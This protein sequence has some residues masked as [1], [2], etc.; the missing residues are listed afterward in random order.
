[1]LS[2]QTPDNLTFSYKGPSPDEG[3]LP[4]LFYFSL[5]AEQSLEMYPYNSP[6]D[7]FKESKC[8]VFSVTLPSHGK[9]PMEHHAIKMW[10]D[11]IYAGHYQLE[12][13]INAVV[14]GIYFLIE[15][16]IVDPEA[17][18][19]SGL[20][21]GAFIAT[22]LAAKIKESKY[23]LGFAPLTY[24]NDLEDF[25]KYKHDMHVQSRLERLNLLSL[26]EELSHLH[27]L[28]FYIGNRD[29]RVGVDHCY[30]FI[31]AL[32]EKAHEK[33]ARS[34]H[35]ELNITQ[36]IGHQGHGTSPATFEEGSLWVKKYLLKE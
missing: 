4:A 27:A 18:A 20:S 17:I 26:I 11:E 36:S 34:F 21:R 1:M 2:I 3:M 31:R 25:V 10:A 22:H 6:I 35:I 29:T 32:S 28:R 19:F 16:N 14:K 7:F 15:Q 13:F 5:S 30:Q 8:R 9:S 33:K 24:F 12:E 23:V